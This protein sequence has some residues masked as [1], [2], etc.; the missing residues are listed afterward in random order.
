METEKRKALHWIKTHKRQ[1]IIAGISVAI[2]VGIVVGIKN[3]S[4]LARYIVKLKDI[5]DGHAEGT[6]R[7]GTIH[8][9]SEKV[10]TVGET[11]WEMTGNKLSTKEL[12][13]VLNQ[14]SRGMNQR[15]IE[16]GLLE[17]LPCGDLVLTE[18]GKLFGECTIKETPWG[19]SAPKFIWDESVKGLLFSEQELI[20]IAE[21]QK[22]VSEI[23]R[24]A[25][26]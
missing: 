19:Y 14:T 20:D 17:R 1:L 3:R 24:K 5:V 16:K 2:A 4:E 13:N 25:A 7:A 9:V 18:K 8:D 6:A 15:F 10:C 22:F 26:S 12:G 23:M 21:R 11:A